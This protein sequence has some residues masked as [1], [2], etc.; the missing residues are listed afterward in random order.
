MAKLAG[1]AVGT[2]QQFPVDNNAASP[3]GSQRN[4]DGMLHPTCAAEQQFSDCGGVG[5]ISDRD[6]QV[7]P[8]PEQFDQ[9]D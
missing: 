4:N 7:I 3:A 9:V 1:A 8:M 6:R 2:V 5:V